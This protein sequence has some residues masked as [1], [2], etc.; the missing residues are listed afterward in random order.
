MY[1][2]KKHFNQSKGE[3]NSEKKDN[4]EQTLS[5][6]KKLVENVETL[7][8]LLNE[9]MPDLPIDGIVFFFSIHSIYVNYLLRNFNF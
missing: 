9:Q 6:Y 7:A 4:Y 5:A 8:D 2:L 1:I 3:L